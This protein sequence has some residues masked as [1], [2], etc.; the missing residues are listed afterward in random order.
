MGSVSLERERFTAWV[1]FQ[2]AEHR[3][4]WRIFTGRYW[5]H[6]FVIV[7][8]YFPKP[9]LNAKVFSQIV[10]PITFCVKVGV[11]DMHPQELAKKLLDEGYTAVIKV[12][13]DHDYKTDYIP[14]GLLT[15]VSLVKAIIGVRAWYVW[16]P[17][18]L[19]RYLVRNGCEMMKRE[20]K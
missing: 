14:R 15:C 10:N 19:A 3:R 20:T 17:K 12:P 13:V 5:R 4:F 8:Y 16:T 1:V 7:P 2:G 9:G 18:H 6:C 11:I